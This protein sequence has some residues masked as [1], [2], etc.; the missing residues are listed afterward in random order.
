M[1]KYISAQILII[2][3]LHEYSSTHVDHAAL[4]IDVLLLERRLDIFKIMMI[5]HNF[6][7]YNCHM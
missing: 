1:G 4:Y 3:D 7:F 5:N 2:Q 6:R